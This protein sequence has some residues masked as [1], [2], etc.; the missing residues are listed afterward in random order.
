MHEKGVCQVW[1]YDVYG[2]QH[3]AFARAYVVLMARWT[4]EKRDVLSGVVYD[5]HASR[6]RDTYPW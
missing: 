3:L 5:F 4:F 1:A 6:R 2:D